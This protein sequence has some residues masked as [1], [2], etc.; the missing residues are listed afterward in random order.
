VAT[1]LLS[2]L[3]KHA[4][5]CAKPAPH[6]Y[7]LPQGMDF[8][9]YL[10]RLEQLLAITCM[11]LDFVDGGGLFGEHEMIDG[12]LHLCVRQPNNVLTR[13]ILAQ[14][15]RQMQKVRPEIISEYKEKIQLLQREHPLSGDTATLI[16]KSLD[17]VIA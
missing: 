7:H 10:L 5:V 12:A 2:L 17:N 8:S 1:K 16:V 6:W 14:T 15:L 13:M 9:D 3:V 4:A 11:H